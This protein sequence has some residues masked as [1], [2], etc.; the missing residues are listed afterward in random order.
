MSA[1]DGN[2]PESVYRTVGSSLVGQVEDSRFYFLTELDYHVL[3]DGAASGKLTTPRDVCIGITGTAIF[4]VIS[5]GATAPNPPSSWWMILLGASCT[6][7]I[8]AAGAAILFHRLAESSKEVS[9]HRTLIAKIERHLATS[10]DMAQGG[11]E[12]KQLP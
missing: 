8:A 5:L 4:T 6:A 11:G 3:R 12:T 10:R 1:P 9:A 2:K 7:T